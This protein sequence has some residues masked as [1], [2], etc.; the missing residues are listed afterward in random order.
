MANVTQ[1]EIARRSGVAVS[2]V[3]KILRRK[4]GASF[5]AETIRRVWRVARE[6]GYDLQ[7]RKYRRRPAGRGSGKGPTGTKVTQAEIARR[8]GVSVSSVSKILCRLPGMSFH[9]ETVDRVFRIARETG[10]DVGAQDY[11]RP[12]EGRIGV[13]LPVEL[14]IYAGDGSVYTTGAA[15]LTRLSP[16]GG[17][18]EGM[19][20]SNMSIPVESRGW[21]IR[22]SW[23]PL[24]GREILGR[25]V[26]LDS[27]SEGGFAVT[28]GFAR[29]LGGAELRAFREMSRSSGRTKD[30]E[31]SSGRRLA[32]TRGRSHA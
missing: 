22:P 21:G 31:K 23:G 29:A 28:L 14:V 4:P 30:S 15:A 6:L 19:V 18:L 10:Y 13:F 11:G 9:W 25:P 20:L 8:A 5:G 3:N 16:A 7:A 27:L 17:V 24:K 1:A 32:S 26:R 2:T 12:S